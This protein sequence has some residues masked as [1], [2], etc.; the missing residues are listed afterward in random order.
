LPFIE[1]EK[2]KQANKKISAQISGKVKTQNK[3]I[4]D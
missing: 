1:N 4:C 2:G 3:R